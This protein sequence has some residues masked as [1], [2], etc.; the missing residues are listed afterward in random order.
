MI[1]ECGLKLDDVLDVMSIADN[2]AVNGEFYYIKNGVCY[3]SSDC[4][5]DGYLYQGE[6]EYIF[7]CQD[8]E[9]VTRYCYRF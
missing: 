8:D 7:C 4:E 6:P 9:A 3:D 2:Y 5:N 1:S